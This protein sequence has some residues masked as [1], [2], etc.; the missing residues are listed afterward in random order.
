MHRLLSPK[1]VQVAAEDRLSDVGARIAA[2]NAS[3]CV[4][5]EVPRGQIIGVV[6]VNEALKSPPRIFADLISRVPVVSLRP[7]EDPVALARRLRRRRLRDAAVVSATGE[8]VGVVTRESLEAWHQS[9]AAGRASVDADAARLRDKI[10]QQQRSLREALQH[11]DELAYAISHD[12]RTPLRAIRGYAEILEEDFSPKLDETAR[13][14]VGRILS[15]SKRLDRLTNGVLAYSRVAR[16]KIVPRRVDLLSPI[17]AARARISEKA[18]HARLSLPSK[19][20]YAD[21][22]PALVEECVLEL[23]QNAVKFGSAAS[24]VEIQVQLRQI[25]SRVRVIVRD[26]GPG[27]SRQN[28]KNLFHLFGRLYGADGDTSAGVGLAVVRKAVERMGGRVG[29]RN[30]TTRG[31]SIWIELPHARRD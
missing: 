12:V 18:P 10:L 15:A 21:A 25:G 11:F 4:V 20:V 8:F 6:R 16:R 28:R 2:R 27:I 9:A 5:R 30:G 31:C 7:E 29:L 23:F 1:V 17:A 14:Y 13:Q 3:H 24:P 26:N 19:A 22:D